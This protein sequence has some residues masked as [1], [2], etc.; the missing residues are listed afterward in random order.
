MGRVGWLGWFVVAGCDGFELRFDGRDIDAPD[1]APPSLWATTGHTGVD[2]T[3]LP[4]EPPTEPPAEPTADDADADGWPV[5]VDC[6]DT[7]PQTTGSW[8]FVDRDADG[9]G[10]GTGTAACAPPS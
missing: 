3:M 2:D 10:K 6:D 4:D 7:D 5:D 8:W 1:E 9:Y